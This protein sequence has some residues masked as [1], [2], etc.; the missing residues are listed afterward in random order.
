MA[1]DGDSPRL[2]RLPFGVILQDF[3]FVPWPSRPRMPP[4]RVVCWHLPRFLTVARASDAARIGGVG[5]QTI[6]DWVLR[7][8]AKGPEGLKD[9][10]APGPTLPP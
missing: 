5:V 6:H 10:K 1:N 3:S 7:F 2:S 8:N 4:L 9:G